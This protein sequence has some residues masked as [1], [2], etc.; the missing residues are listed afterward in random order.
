MGT[1]TFEL[2]SL[3]I[4]DWIQSGKAS[5]T[6]YGLRGMQN[7]QREFLKKKLIL[8]A[9]AGLLMTSGVSAQSRTTF[10]G[11]SE[12]YWTYVAD[13]TGEARFGYMP[14]CQRLGLLGVDDIKSFGYSFFSSQIAGSRQLAATMRVHQKTNGLEHTTFAAIPLPWCK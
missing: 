12:V 6:S 9:L 1:S 14:H 5:P 4:S 11:L 7:T 13:A 3:T 10:I 8:A 2:I